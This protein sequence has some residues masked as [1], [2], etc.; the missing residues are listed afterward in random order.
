MKFY[1][2][3]EGI[4]I[5]K[6]KRCEVFQASVPGNIQ[7]DYGKAVGF[8]D[9]MYGENCEKFRAVENDG[10]EYRTRLDYKKSDRERVWF[11]SEG[12]DYKYNILLNGECIYSYEGMFKPVE[13]DITEKL[14]GNDELCVYIYPHPKR[15]GARE[16]SR[17]EADACCKPPVCYGWDWNPR[18]LISGMWQDAYIETRTESYIGACEPIYKLDDTLTHAKVSFNIACGVSCTVNLYDADGGLLYSGDGQNLELEDVKLWWCNGQGEPYLYKWTVENTECKREGTLGFRRVRLLRNDNAHDP[19]GFPK[20]RYPAPIT[21]ELNGRRIF[22]KGSNFVNADIFWGNITDGIY[23]TLTD[24]AVDANMNILRLW[25]GASIHKKALYELCDKKGIMLWQE[26]MLACNSYPNDEKYL[27]VLE[28]EATAMIKALRH[29]PSLV[30]WCGGNELFNGWSGMSDQSLA[31]RLLDSLCLRYDREKPYLMTSP[32]EGMGHGGYMFY[33]KRYPWGDV[34][35]C[36]QGSKHT[37]YTEFGV[38]SISPMEVLEKI[39]PEEE[40]SEIRETP[41]WKLHHAVR[42]WMAQSHACVEVLEMYFGKDATV[43]ERVEQSNWLQ[44]EGMKAIFEEARRQ[45]PH[46]SAA[47]NWAFNEPWMT[48]A[49]LSVLRYPDIPKPGYYA[50]KAALRPALFSAR[51]PKFDW[52]SGERFTA[53]IWLLNDSPEARDGSVEVFLQIGETEISLLQWKGASAEAQTNIE[54]ASVCCMLPA[55]DTDRMRLVLRA[56]DKDMSSEY[57]LLYE[58]KK[59]T[60]KPKGMNM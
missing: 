21:L 34:F 50:V 15:E 12:I 13:L 3:W 41:S 42:A 28:S 23:D 20:S 44:V 1:Q 2:K 43:S 47:L 7:C 27:S 33:D 37:A 39:I 17:D 57:T 24:L 35:K 26:F 9:V 29:H 46:C 14:L 10:W 48:A 8:G 38:P 54:G 55:V 31:L 58:R 45:S 56:A 5:H 22:M 25:G 51:I 52:K 4:R 40:L 19:S 30:M 6:E 53:E 16:G 32:L 18:L 36:F 59:Q 49:N 60:P 11:V